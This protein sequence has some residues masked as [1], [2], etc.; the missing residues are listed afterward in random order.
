MRLLERQKGQLWFTVL[1]I[2]VCGLSPLIFSACDK[3]VHDD[4]GMYFRVSRSLCGDQ[5]TQR[6]IELSLPQP[7][8]N[9]SSQ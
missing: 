6:K 4:K 1:V 9:V 8:K 2:P 3:T 5:E 7:S